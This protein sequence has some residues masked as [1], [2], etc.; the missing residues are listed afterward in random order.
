MRLLALAAALLLVTHL[1]TAA[2]EHTGNVTQGVAT[3]IDG[4]T[5]EIHGSRIRL[6]GIDAP[7][8][9]QTCSESDGSASRCG[10]VA[11]LF[12]AEKIGRTPILCEHLDMDRY[13]R[14]IARCFR[15]REDL[16]K[17]MVGEG[18]A[19]AYRQYSFDYIADEDQAREARKGVWRTK[20]DM[21]W[22]WRKG[23]R[24]SEGSDEIPERLQRLVQGSYSCSPRRTCSQ[25]GSCQEARWYLDNCSW[26]SR[27]D[28]D[29]DGVPCE[30]IC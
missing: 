6:H 27:L 30:S 13:G 28:R 23:A 25:I 26:G 24:T 12:L 14:I 21:P 5:L 17:W 4:D 15:N 18:L 19:V 22:D 9:R 29:S 10:Q 7:E 8:S 11:A 20:F 16:N 1:P 2:A 3:V